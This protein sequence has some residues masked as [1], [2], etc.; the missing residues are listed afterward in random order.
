[1]S[2]TKPS[3]DQWLIEA[4]ADPSASNIGMYLTH[5]G[6]VRQSPRAQVREGI[7]DGT[8]VVGMT[9]D[10]DDALLAAAVEEAKSYEGIFYIRVWL[11]RGELNVGDDIMYVL[12][13]GDIRDHTVDGL[14]KLVKKIKT[15]IVVEIEKKA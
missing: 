6:V 10:Y 15:E 1:M 4:K 7:D 11:A 3:I 2:I 12:V 9:F 8:E 14:L 13:G 5:N